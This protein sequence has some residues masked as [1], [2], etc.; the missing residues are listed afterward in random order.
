MSITEEEKQAIIDEVIEKATP[1]ITEKV[2]LLIPE[3]IGNLMVN[4]ISMAKLNK[5]FLDA[6]P[7]FKNHKEAVQSVVEMIE[8]RDPLAKYEDILKEAVPEIR[9]RIET[10]KKVDMKTISAN[11]DRGFKQLDAPSDKDTV[12]NDPNGVI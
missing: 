11:P 1:T 12:F 7:E 3:V 6:H 5:K 9:K 8:G 2:L 10:M 4:H